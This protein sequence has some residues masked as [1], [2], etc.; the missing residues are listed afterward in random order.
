[1][2]F[3]GIITPLQC[4]VLNGSVQPVFH[5]GYIPVNGRSCDFSPLFS[6]ILNQITG[7]SGIYLKRYTIIGFYW[8]GDIYKESL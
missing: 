8:T 2:R 6:H 7:I 4:I 3:R 5:I 1:M